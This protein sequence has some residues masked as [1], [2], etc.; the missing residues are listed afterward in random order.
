[1]LTDR[2]VLLVT[3]SDSG[4][5]AFG[6]AFFV[7]RDSDGRAYAV[8]C[9]HVVR[10]VGGADAVNVGGRRARLVVM[11]SPQG[12]DDIAVLE[13]DAPAGALPLGLG[14]ARSDQRACRVIGFRRLYADVRQAGSIDGVSA[15][16]GPGGCG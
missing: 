9:A 11:G 10:D 8:T 1:M 12:A 7:G 6:T 2:S 16:R 14:R 15:S 13:I 4:T 5:P 3:S